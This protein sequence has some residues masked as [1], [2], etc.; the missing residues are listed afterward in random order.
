MQANF[1]NSSV[2]LP[3]LTRHSKQISY[4]APTKSRGRIERPRPES[5]SL[6]ASYNISFSPDQRA[7]PEVFYGKSTR[8]SKG[9]DPV[10]RKKIFNFAS[11]SRQQSKSEVL[12]MKLER[13]RKK[14]NQLQTSNE[15]R[16]RFVRQIHADFGVKLS[17]AEVLTS[18]EESLLLKIKREVKD[19]KE[20]AAASF[21]Q[22]SWEHKSISI[23]HKHKFDLES[24]NAK[25]IQKWWTEKITSRL[26]KVT[27]YKKRL[28]AALFIQAYY[29]AYK[30][31][32]DKL[33]KLY[34]SKLQLG[35]IELE[36]GIL[37]VKTR[38]A[39]IIARNWRDYKQ[40]QLVRAQQASEIEEPT[41]VRVARSQT[42]QKHN[43]STDFMRKALRRSTVMKP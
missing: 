2:P 28:R 26:K 39:N 8:F 13:S 40:R 10:Y 17:K 14:L 41:I 27:E 20:N 21:I 22:R 15:L 6:Y 30:A 19:K 33:Y 32:Q 11:V 3:P 37:R 36:L 18:S 34:K 43:Q 1:Y 38:A 29:R 16:R 5:V 42:F 35:L 7:S 9:Y 4:V 12:K 31:R 24:S 25:V 23:K